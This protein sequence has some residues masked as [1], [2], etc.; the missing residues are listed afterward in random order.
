MSLDLYNVSQSYQMVQ[1]H[2]QEM[3]KEFARTAPVRDAMAV[4]AAE[5]KAMRRFRLMY[6]VRRWMHLL[7]PGVARIWL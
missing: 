4:Q 7:A 2:Q 1:F 6:R 5:R 3:R